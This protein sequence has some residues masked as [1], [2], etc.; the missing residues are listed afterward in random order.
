VTAPPSKK[1]ERP[2]CEKTQSSFGSW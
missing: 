1:T 2:W